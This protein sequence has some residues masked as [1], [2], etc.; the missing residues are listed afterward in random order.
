MYIQIYDLNFFKKIKVIDNKNFCYMTKMLS[1][2]LIV[3]KT[4]FHLS[5]KNNNFIGRGA[6]LLFGKKN[7]CATCISDASVQ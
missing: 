4:K 1:I 3:H 5:E 6:T 2:K 7:L